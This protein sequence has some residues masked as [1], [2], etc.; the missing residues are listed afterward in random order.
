[1][2]KVP[3]GVNFGAE[4]RRGWQKIPDGLDFVSVIETRREWQK[5]PDGLNFVSGTE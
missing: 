4:S 3:E 5:V 2:T 1:M